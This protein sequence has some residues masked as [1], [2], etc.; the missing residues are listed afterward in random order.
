VSPKRERRSGRPLSQLS[1]IP[2][3]VLLEKER[4]PLVV[5]EGEGEGEGEKGDGSDSEEEVE[6]VIEDKKSGRKRF[7][8]HIVHCFHLCSL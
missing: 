2:A 6:E 5:E 1:D 7:R 4:E 8:L 3:P